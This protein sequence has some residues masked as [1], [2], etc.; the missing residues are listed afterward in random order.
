MLDN[1][2]LKERLAR[3]GPIR[4]AVPDRLFSDE[5]EAVVLC[6]VGPF[7]D[8][9]TVLKHL[10]ASGLGLKAAHAAI[11]ELADQD[12]TLVHIPI[13][14]GI[15]DLARDLLP[16]DVSLSRQRPV[17]QPASFIAGVRA[18]HR[19][20]QRDFAGL[21]GLDVRTLQNWE[22]GRNAP[23]AAAVNLVA[24]FDRDP[25]MVTACLFQPV[26]VAAE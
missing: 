5:V 16:L 1:S 20:S 17:D 4:D 7:P 19:L 11:T 24:L 25:A 12:W 6:R 26:A 10:R 18:K 2:K 8:R 9:I 23:D 13:D 3:L 22:Q 14:G 15:E 21:L